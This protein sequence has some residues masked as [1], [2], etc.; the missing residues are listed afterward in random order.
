MI[1]LELI[2]LNAM[3]SG[4]TSPGGGSNATDLSSGRYC[5]LYHYNNA[6]D[7]PMN[8]TC[9]KGSL[10]PAAVWEWWWTTRVLAVIINVFI[11]FCQNHLVSTSV[12]TT[13]GQ[14]II[15]VVVV[16]VVTFFG[17]S[18]SLGIEIVLDSEV[19]LGWFLY[20]N[21]KIYQV[22]AEWGMSTIYRLNLQLINVYIIWL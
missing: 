20:L 21:P 10:V 8:F 16:V 9:F 19:V 3:G 22:E 18:L 11:F 7:L 2:E 14:G 15:R 12:G 1:G 6:W 13:R 17:H 4:G 5:P